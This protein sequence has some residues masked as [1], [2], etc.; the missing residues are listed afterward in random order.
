MRKRRRG[1]RLLLAVAA[2]TVG[3]GTVLIV[4]GTAT[5]ESR[6]GANAT[7][8]FWP[9]YHE[10][11][12]TLPSPP[13]PATNTSC[14]WLLEVNEPDVPAQT[15]LGTATGS[16]GMLTVT[17]SAAFCG[18][19]QADALIGPSPWFLKYGHRDTV[20]GTDC[21]TPVTTPPV[22]TP[23]V[24]SPPAVTPVANPP[25]AVVQTQLPYTAPTT[26]TTAAPAA[27]AVTPTS[28]VTATTDP[29]Q[30]PFTG[31]NVKPLVL[32]GSGLI[33][34]GLYVL[35]TIEQRRRALMRVGYSVRT[36]PVG[37]HTGRITRWL[38]GD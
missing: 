22:T 33:L 30:L 10:V 35:T 15:V 16:S 8:H 2:A 24:T 12:L 17:Y 34:A 4:A 3:L 29:A 23:P 7:I 26:P 20:T 38:F 18:V 37:V 1:A 11:T 32:V 5:A 28:A 9:A 6:V 25:A 27:A 19:I 21:A 13:C 36:N 31:V 14:E